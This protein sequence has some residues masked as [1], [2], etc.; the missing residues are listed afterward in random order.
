MRWQ[1]VCASAREV[2][3]GHIAI[4]WAVVAFADNVRWH[5]EIYVCVCVCLLQAV[6][7]ADD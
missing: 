3:V 4:P 5:P 1:N 6:V 2:R 7:V